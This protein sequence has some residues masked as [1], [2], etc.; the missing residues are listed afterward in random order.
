MEDSA[1]HIPFNSELSIKL[2]K[3]ESRKKAKSIF[4]IKKS[5]DPEFT[6]SSYAPSP[7]DD[8]TDKMKN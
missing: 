4:S 2:T 3:D 1:E 5:Y 6:I 7:D 8:D